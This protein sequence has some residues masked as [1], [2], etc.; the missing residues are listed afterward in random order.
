MKIFNDKKIVITGVIS[1]KINL[2]E[3]LSPLRNL[4]VLNKGVISEVFIQRRGSSRSNKP[5]GSKKMDKPLNRNTLISKGKIK[6]LQILISKSNID[7][8]IFINPLTEHQKS[9][10]ETE[11]G[12]QIISKAAIFVE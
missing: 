6:E 11:I 10:L 7:L 9:T 1:A 5:G 3:Y 2:E 8:V 4:I 12:V